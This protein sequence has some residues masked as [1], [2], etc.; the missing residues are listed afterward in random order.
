MLIPVVLAAVGAVMVPWCDKPGLPFE[1]RN[2][3][4]H[5]IYGAPTGALTRQSVCCGTAISVGTGWPEYQW[6]QWE[7]L[8]VNQYLVHGL[9]R[10][11]NY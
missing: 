4:V 6:K 9:V 1:V 5:C 2:M 3:L 7:G 10:A 11:D 8:H